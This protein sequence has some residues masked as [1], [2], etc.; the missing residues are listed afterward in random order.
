MLE[1]GLPNITVRLPADLNNDGTY[2][3]IATQ[4][5]DADGA[6]LFANLPSLTSRVVVDTADADLPL[7]GVGNPYTS[8]TGTDQ[9]V[10]ISGNSGHDRRLRLR[11][12]GCAGRR[13]LL[14]RERQWPARLERNRHRRCDCDAGE[15][16]QHADCV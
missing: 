4:T 6:Y 7:D 3:T 10:T 9:S 16:R 15:C 11:A 13:D 8:T 14:G 5:T 2:V 12:S 1:T